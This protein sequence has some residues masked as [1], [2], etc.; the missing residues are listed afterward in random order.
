MPCTFNEVTAV[1]VR[2]LDSARKVRYR[3]AAVSE[4]IVGH[5]ES[6]PANIRV[7]QSRVTTSYV[8][9][10]SSL[11]VRH[12]RR[13]RRYLVANLIIEVPDDLARSLEAIAAAQRKSLQQLALERLHSLVEMSSE[14]RAGSAAA[15]L[16]VMQ[17]P[18]HPSVADVAELDAAI[19][20]GRLPTGTRDLFSD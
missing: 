3:N 1:L 5:S 12:N 11:G 18:P 4:W 20:A 16:R 10:V 17:E 14:P 6:G 13:G 15:I 19:A 9:L 2:V 7:V 8:G